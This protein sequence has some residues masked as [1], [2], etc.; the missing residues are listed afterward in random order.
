MRE[1]LE[2]KNLDLKGKSNYRL[3]NIN[4][5][6][7]QGEKIALLGKSGAGKST[8]ISVANGTIVPTRG[9]VKWK[10]KILQQRTK[11]E[12]SAIGTL[13]QDLRLVEELNVSQNIN[14]GA[15]GR[16]NLC[17][18]MKNIISIIDRKE[19]TEIIESLGLKKEI[20]NMPIRKI[21]G[22]QRQRVAIARL[23]KQKSELILADEPL[24]NLDPKTSSIILNILLKKQHIASIPYHDTILMSLHQPDLINHFTR[25]IGLKNGELVLDVES[26]NLTLSEINLI[27]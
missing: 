4:L 18:A 8:L 17:W 22:G 25:V 10:G 26:K 1:I 12:A 9:N 20:L 16:H 15:L 11:R 13:W 2:I 23:L 14:S 27:Y 21:S 7:Y 24:C 5:S 19:C 6:I 3:K